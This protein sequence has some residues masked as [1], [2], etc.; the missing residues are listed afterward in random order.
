MELNHFQK[1][2]WNQTECLC[3]TTDL[4]Q[5][6]TPKVPQSLLQTKRQR[7]PRPLHVHY[8]RHSKHILILIIWHLHSLHELWHRPGRQILT[9]VA[10]H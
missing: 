8:E 2:E 7:M 6:L 5:T 3:A 9:F 1:Y 4:V 10:Y